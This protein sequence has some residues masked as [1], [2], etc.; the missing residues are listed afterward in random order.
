MN[1]DPTSDHPFSK[2]SARPLETPLG[3]GGLLLHAPAKINLNLLVAPPRPDGFHPIDSMVAKITLY[4]RLEL[5]P[6]SDGEIALD[7]CGADCGPPE[8]NL[9]TRAATRLA[10]GRDVCG[11]DIKL[12]K[13]IPAGA[14]LGGGSSDAAAALRG[15][16]KLWGLDLDAGALS[17]LGAE[18]GSDVPL[19][20]GPPAARITGR[21]E[22]VERLEV[23]EFTAI[24]VMGGLMCSTVEVYSTYDRLATA[25]ELQQIDPRTLTAERPSVWRGSLQNDLSAA[26]MQ[27]CPEL[28]SLRDRVSAM[29]DAPVHITGS[30]SAMF[31]LC[32]EATDAS[33]IVSRLDKDLQ[34]MC[35]IVG[36]N[37]W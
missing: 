33:E 10:R 8:R 26:A 12:T 14:G 20:L 25:G 23:G 35:M 37:P 36:Q 4:D 3:A 1:Q 18:L 2:L 16:N 11:V 32:D 19:F 24:L 31:I 17:D 5:R 7:C 9:V 30:G 29:I 15:L 22:C 13:V 34:E 27:V 28:S 6:R 21:G